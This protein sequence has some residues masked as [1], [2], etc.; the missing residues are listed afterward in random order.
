MISSCNLEKHLTE[1]VIIYLPF[2]TDII[3]QSLQNGKFPDI[4]KLAEVIPLFKKADLLD[5]INY[6]PVSL[7]LHMSKVFERIIFNEINKYIEPFLSNLLTGFCKNYS[8][9]LSIKTARKI[10]R[11]FK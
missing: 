9:T 8:T 7:L 6:Q 3:D 11:S 5:K 1:S 4:L 2:L 10:E